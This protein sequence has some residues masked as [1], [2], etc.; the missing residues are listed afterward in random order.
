MAC[1]WTQRGHSS[2]R[3]GY[4]S[5]AALSISA[6]EATV[7]REFFMMRAIGAEVAARALG[8]DAKQVSMLRRP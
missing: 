7:A 1:Q 4:S 5:T 6:H 2:G 3:A 8:E